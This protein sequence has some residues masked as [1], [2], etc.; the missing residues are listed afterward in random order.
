VIDQ[1]IRSRK[2]YGYSYTHLI[3]KHEGI[4]PSDGQ[5]PLT[6]DTDPAW[7]ELDTLQLYGGV[8]TERPDNKADA[9]RGVLRQPKEEDS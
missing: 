5:F 6:K 2:Q 8:S 3:L 9:V 4:D 7:P 1:I